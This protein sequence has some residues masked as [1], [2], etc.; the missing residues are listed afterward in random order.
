[1]AAE[2]LRLSSPKRG[3]YVLRHRLGAGRHGEVWSAT[4]ESS[5][6]IWAIRVL[7][8]PSME[9][10]Q[11]VPGTVQGLGCRHLPLI[12]EAFVDVTHG[13]YCIV[14]ETVSGSQLDRLM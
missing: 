11:S 3:A 6:G 13:L 9:P 1:M 4:E 5:H 2:G 12:A 14:M 8:Q 7:K 10:D